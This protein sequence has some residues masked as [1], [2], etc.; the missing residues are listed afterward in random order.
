MRW[1]A[2]GEEMV[3][4][5]RN[6]VVPFLLVV[7]ACLAA[8]LLLGSV[9]GGIFLPQASAGQPSISFT[10]LGY[11]SLQQPTALRAIWVVVLDGKG[12]AEYLG[13]SPATVILTTDGQAAVLREFL[14]D[15]SGAPARLFQVGKIPEPSTAVE[16][17]RQGFI[18]IVNRMGGVRLEG[19]TYRGQEV[20]S[21][22]ETETDPMEQLRLQSRI[23]TALFG[24]AGPCPGESALAGLHPAHL[25]SNLP[26]DMLIAECTKRG[27]YL[28]GAVKVDVL[29][30]VLPLDLPDGSQGFWPKE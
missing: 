26:P 11:D 17:D 14:A 6:K 29:D 5:H 4:Q 27:P 28:S 24:A 20:L 8:G 13:I 1:E 9:A 19:R 3:P 23:V 22:L 15:P 7:G 16:F 21:V 12:K 18:M 25:L 30:D 2:A 10:L